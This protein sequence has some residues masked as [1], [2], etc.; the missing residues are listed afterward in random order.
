M[1]RIA[2]IGIDSFSISLIKIFSG[3]LKYISAI[4]SDPEQV[5]KIQDMVNYSIV[6]NIENSETISSFLNNDIDTA[7]ISTGKNIT[8]SIFA[9]YHLIEMGIKKIYA[10]AISEDH[11]KILKEM[12][13]KEIISPEKDTA[14]HLFDKLSDAH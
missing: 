1:E 3:K 4:D 2:I 9:V 5:A 10:R 8:A 14:E 11:A 7:F 6:G 13:I 12:G